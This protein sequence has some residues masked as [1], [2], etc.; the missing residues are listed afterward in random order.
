MLK[1]KVKEAR[2]IHYSQAASNYMK[3]NQSDIS[4]NYNEFKNDFPN[5][6]YLADMAYNDQQTVQD[7]Y[8]VNQV[9]SVVDMRDEPS[10]NNFH[11]SR[12]IMDDLDKYEDTEK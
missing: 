12:N 7:D 1:G 2:S 3:D 4:Q 9:L 11:H 6:L 5:K 8:Q 10:E